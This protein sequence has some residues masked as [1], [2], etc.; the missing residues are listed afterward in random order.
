MD[1]VVIGMGRAGGAVARA[2]EATGSHRVTG[3]LSRRV[4]GLFPALG[5]DEP[6]PQADLALVA[7][8][9]AAIAEVAERLAPHWRPS[10]PA[11]HL[12]GFTSIHALDPIAATGAEV[13]SFHPLQT[14]ADPESGARALAGSWVAV[15]AEGELRGRLERLAA[16]LDMV[17]LPLADEA[18][19][20]YHAAASAASNFVVEA[21]AVASDLLAAAGID[22]AAVEP[23]T[24]RVVDNVFELGPGPAL[25]GPI[26]RGDRTT[27]TGQRRA[28]A[29]VSERLGAE[30]DLLA[31]ATATRVGTDL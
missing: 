17:A 31:R 16:D 30:F 7:V 15:T 27:V 12:S 9:D 25:T 21:L 3:V 29:E 6:L 18:K 1:I 14:L 22:F 10:L 4:Q 24:R 13:G 26:A 11:A 20:V 8:A 19:A 28:A 2:V 5:W 23:L